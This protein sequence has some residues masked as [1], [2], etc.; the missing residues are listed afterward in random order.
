[1][2]GNG[3]MNFACCVLL[4]DAAPDFL[5]KAMGFG[6]AHRHSTRTGVFVADHTL[7]RPELLLGGKICV[8]SQVIGADAER[9]HLAHQM[10]RGDALAAH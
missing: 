9:I 5:C 10:L 7:Y 1:M 3:H 8:R 4:F 2:D 6:A